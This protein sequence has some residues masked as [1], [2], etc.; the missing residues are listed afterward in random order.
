M[1]NKPSI[2]VCQ[3]R[4]CRKDGSK[5]VLKAFES[6]TPPDVKII[7]CG[8]LGQCGNGPNIVVLPEKNLYQQVSVKD[9]S[10][11]FLTNKN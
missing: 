8:C 7:P 9:I 10:T 5:Q 11:L 3:G 1:E 6:E 4:C 2:L